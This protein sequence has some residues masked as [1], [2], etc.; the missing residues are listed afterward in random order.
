MSRILN[1]TKW[2]I[3]FIILFLSLWTRFS[4]YLDNGKLSITVRPTDATV[5]DEAY[6]IPQVENYYFNQYYFDPHP[7][8]GKLILFLGTKLYDGTLPNGVSN[9]DSLD[10][11]KLA[12]KVDDYKNLLNPEGFRIF[13][14][15]FGSL[16]GPVI[17]LIIYEILNRN[18]QRKNYLVPFLTSLLGIFE[19]TYIVESRYGL[20]SQ[21]LLFFMLVT[22][23]FILKYF[24]TSNRKKEFIFLIFTSIFF[25]LGVSTKWF[26]LSGIVFIGILVLAKC[27]SNYISK[28]NRLLQIATDSPEKVI[29]KVGMTIERFR[30]ELNSGLRLI[31]VTLASSIVR[32]FFIVLLSL[33]IYMGV[34]AVHFSLIKNYNYIP[35]VNNQEVEEFCP[36]WVQDLK[37]GTNNA[38]YFCKFY[39]YY[40]L[41]H[42][43]EEHVGPLDLT[44]PDEIG[45]AWINWPI[46][47]RTISYFWSTDGSNKY[48]FIYLL[49]NPIV[50]LFVLIS[51]Y[52]GTSFLIVRVF[53]VKSNY[54]K[55]K[56]IILSALI[57]LYF[58]NWLP[59]ATI[60]RVM[61]L[62]HYIPALSIGILIFGTLLGEVISPYLNN[63]QSLLLN[64]LLTNKLN[65]NDED[66]TIIQILKIKGLFFAI[67]F[68]LILMLILLGYI[69]YYPFAYLFPVSKDYFQMV[70]LIKDWGMKWPGN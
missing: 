7:P 33:L 31:I 2:I 48:A 14:R 4:P 25:G 56:F 42:K 45:S 28:R 34:F 6:F 58:S 13:P 40:K 30:S 69:F 68:I 49:G 50:W 54:L 1:P 35:D 38:N 18:R 39:A 43:Y 9:K 41:Q 70:N 19:I 10:P 29:E 11:T 24:F 55:D 8:L 66:S 23:F 15:I 32:M 63:L 64:K 67:L 17:F 47:N 59:F 57:T 12:N 26:A 22:I 21:I 60:P 61:Y 27:C 44:K 37:N 53:G 51:V 62:Y 5:F 52:I 36:E 46:M 16:I 65:S 20:L 3:F